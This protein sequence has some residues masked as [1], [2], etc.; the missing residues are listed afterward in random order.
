MHFNIF[1]ANITT[2]KPRRLHHKN[3]KIKI[4]YIFL[5]DL[6]KCLNLTKNNKIIKMNKTIEILEKS[7]KYAKKQLLD[8]W[9]KLSEEE[10]LQ[11]K[12]GISETLNFI[13]TLKDIN[14][15]I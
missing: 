2:A 11:I 8:N 1:S 3:I 6:K 12:R 10:T 15:K 5:V 14:K 7:I 4:I 13:E 9:E